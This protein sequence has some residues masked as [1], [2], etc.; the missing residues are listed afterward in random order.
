VGALGRNGIQALALT[1]REEGPQIGFGVDTGLA[2]E[3]GKI[4]QDRYPEAGVRKV[5]GCDELGCVS[6]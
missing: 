4:G 5:A 2:L 1:P 3:P 6:S